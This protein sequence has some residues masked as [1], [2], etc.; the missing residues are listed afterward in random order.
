MASASTPPPPP[1]ILSTPLATPIPPIPVILQVSLPTRSRSSTPST[2][3]QTSTA[4]QQHRLRQPRGQLWQ[5]RQGLGPG[6]LRL[7]RRGQQ[8]RLRI[9][10]E[11]LRQVG[12]RRGRDAAFEGLGCLDAF[13]AANGF[14]ADVPEPALLPVLAAMFILMQ[15]R[16]PKQL[17]HV[18]DL[19][20]AFT[21][22]AS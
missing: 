21:S 1:A 12:Q 20:R 9:A 16:R 18:G 14:M 10:R 19:F 8:H 2:A 7:Q 17:V 3:T 6:R 15:R 5:I 22:A 4:G 13:A 11:Q